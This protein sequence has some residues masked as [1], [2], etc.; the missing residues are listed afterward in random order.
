MQK[1]MYTLAT[2]MNQ[3]TGSLI[4]IRSEQSAANSW[5]SARIVYLPPLK[6]HSTMKILNIGLGKERGKKNPLFPFAYGK[7]RGNFLI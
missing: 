3:S 2:N 6:V 5:C 1:K 7:E 4:R